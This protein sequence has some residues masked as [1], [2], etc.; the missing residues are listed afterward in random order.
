MQLFYGGVSGQNNLS[1][2][3][4]QIPSQFTGQNHPHKILVQNPPSPFLRQNPLPEILRQNP[5]PEILRQNPL[6]SEFLLENSGLALINPPPH[7]ISTHNTIPQSLSEDSLGLV[8]YQSESIITDSGS[9][10]QSL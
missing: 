4:Q 3:Y 8:N 6:S 2:F 7:Y 5:P 10:Y 9:T 1:G